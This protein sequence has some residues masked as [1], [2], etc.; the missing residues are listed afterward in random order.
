MRRKLAEH[1]IDRIGK[2]ARQLT[3]PDYGKCDLLIG[4]DLSE[5]QNVR[6][7]CG[8][9]VGGKTRLLMEHTGRPRRCCRP[10]VCG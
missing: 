9:D 1:G 6:R 4:K 3:R 2:E 8:G 10:M 5:I 7:I